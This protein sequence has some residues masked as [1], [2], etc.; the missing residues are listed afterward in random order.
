GKLIDDGTNVGVGATTSTI[1]FEI[2]QAGT[3]DPFLIASSTSANYLIVKAN[4]LVGIGS[5]TPIATLSVQ[6]TSTLPTTNVLVVASSTGTSLLTVAANGSTT[7]SSLTTG[8]VYSTSAGALYINGT[9]G[10]G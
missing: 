8:P 6:G 4:G 9:T 5:S 7:L 1:S 3:L 2:Q 10:T